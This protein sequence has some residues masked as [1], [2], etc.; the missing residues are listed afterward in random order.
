MVG[1][2]GGGGGLFLAVLSTTVVSVA[3]PTIGADLQASA[4]DLQWIVDAY[5]LVYASLLV[6]GGVLGD[7]QGRKG[8]FLLGVAIFGL[9]SLLCG[10]AP[11]VGVLLVGRVVQGLGPALLVPGSL[12]I[13]RATFADPKLRA[14]AIGLWSTASGLA[15]AVGPVLGGVLVDGLGWR[16]VFLSNVP[17]VA[18]LLGL[19][20]RFVPRL[21]RTPAC[22]RFDWLGAALT[23]AG[24]AGLAFGII[25]GQSGGGRP[26]RCWPRSLSA[27]PPWVSSSG[28]N[29]TGPSR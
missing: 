4:T 16:W 22:E 18:V 28:G 2:G 24:V 1:A 6:A 21:P 11:S 9:G 13:V 8:M 5:V 25:H 29:A 14:V 26:A 17:P 7:R 3:L 20:V 10:V 15:L 19:A 12:T 23:T 27:S